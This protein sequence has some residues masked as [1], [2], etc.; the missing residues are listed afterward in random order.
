MTLCEEGRRRD[1]A[2]AGDPEERRYGRFLASHGFELLV[3]LLDSLLEISSLLPEHEEGRVD[4]LRKPL[5][6][7]GKEP[8]QVVHEFAKPPVER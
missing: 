2:D 4:P 7:V 6:L 3:D 5:M 8:V 1:H